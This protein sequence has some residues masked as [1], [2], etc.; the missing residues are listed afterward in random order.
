M[1]ISRTAALIAY[2]TAALIIVAMILL[3]LDYSFAEALFM[4]S[5]FLPGAVAAKFFISQAEMGGSCKS[6]MNAVYIFGAIAVLEFL[7]I[8][9]GHRLLEYIEEQSPLY[10]GI[11]V[12]DILVNPIFVA[13]I[14]L[15]ILA[16]EHLVCQKFKETTEVRTISFTSDRRKIIMNC[17]EISYIESN[18]SEVWVVAD[19]G[20]RFRNK[21]G[22]SQWE[23]LLGKDFIRVHRSYVVRKELIQ[24]TFYDSLTLV[25][26]TT[27][28]VSRKYR[29]IVASLGAN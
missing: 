20:R 1:K 27:I 22:I 15:L 11:G 29:D 9:I 16:G 8:V 10:L 12:A 24:E 6:V 5:L 14:I 2:W 28:P 26:G 19:D 13:V 17:N 25:D 3:S 21:T 7:L 18:D 23:N 4:S